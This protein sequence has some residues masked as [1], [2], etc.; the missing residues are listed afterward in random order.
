M[1]LYSD[2][3][4]PVPSFKYA[5]L[6]TG[7]PTRGLSVDAVGLDGAP[8]GHTV[9]YDGAVELT[10]VTLTIA[11]VAALGTGPMP[12]TSTE[13]LS[14]WPSGPD[15]PLPIPLTTVSILTTT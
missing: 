14:C 13:L 8:V 2:R 11:A 12:A 7:T 10:D 6:G 3:C 5:R 4:P 15:T 1:L 9:M